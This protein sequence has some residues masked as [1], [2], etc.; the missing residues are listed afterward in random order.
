MRVIFFEFPAE[1][2][3]IVFIGTVGQYFFRSGCDLR[4]C[5]KFS[6]EVDP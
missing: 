4:R 1:F 5:R 6:F 3:Y 2:F